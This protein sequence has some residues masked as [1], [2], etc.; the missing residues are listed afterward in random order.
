MVQVWWLYELDVFTNEQL[1]HKRHLVCSD[2]IWHL[3]C[4]WEVMFQPICPYI[5]MRRSTMTAVPILHIHSDSITL[6][7]NC[8]FST[9]EKT[10]LQIYIVH[11][12]QLLWTLRK[13][14][15][16]SCLQLYVNDSMSL[17]LQA[18]PHKSTLFGVYQ[19]LKWIIWSKKDLR[20]HKFAICWFQYNIIANPHV[21]F[22]MSQRYGTLLLESVADH[23]SESVLPNNSFRDSIK[24]KVTPWCAWTGTEGRQRHSSNPFTTQHKKVSGHYHSLATLHPGKTQYPLY[25]RL[26]GPHEASLDNT[27]NLALHRYSTLDCPACSKSLYHLMPSWLPLRDS[28]S[29]GTIGVN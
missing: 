1:I 20:K 9:T 22:K 4:P 17:L 3:W 28:I 15:M 16:A 14:K 26:G 5:N 19:Y 23:I 25:R 7:N 21:R 8:P 29:K 13:T 24:V 10:V 6:W 18:L 2:S 12:S 27:E 11:T